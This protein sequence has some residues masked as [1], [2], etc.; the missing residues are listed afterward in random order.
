M[1]DSILAA[2][3]LRAALF[4]HATHVDVAEPQLCVNPEDVRQVLD[5]QAEWQGIAKR[6]HTWGQR[7]FD[8]QMTG[9]GGGEDELK[10]IILDA[11]KLL[12]PVSEDEKMLLAE[13]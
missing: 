2:T 6:L 7:Y 4:Q 3:T 9:T 12:K 5:S 8:A 11:D 10:A 1:K 13:A